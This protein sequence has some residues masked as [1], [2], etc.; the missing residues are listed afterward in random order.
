MTELIFQKTVQ[1]CIE[2]LVGGTG[3]YDRINIVNIEPCLTQ[4]EFGSV[5][6][7]TSVGKFYTDESLLFSGGNEFTVDNQGSSAILVADPNTARKAEDVHL[8]GVCVDIDIVKFFAGRSQVNCDL[9]S[10]LV[11]TAISAEKTLVWIL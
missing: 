6:R 7:Q 10:G 11:S 2:I 5:P 1:D 9:N 8:S 3:E 4:A